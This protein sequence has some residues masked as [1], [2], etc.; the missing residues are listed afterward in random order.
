MCLHSS[1]CALSCS[2]CAH[3][4]RVHAHQALHHG[5]S[6]ITQQHTRQTHHTQVFPPHDI[7]PRVCQG[8]SED[9]RGVCLCLWLNHTSSCNT[10]T[11]AREQTMP[12]YMASKREHMMHMSTE[13]PSVV[14]QVQGRQHPI[15]VKGTKHHP[16]RHAH[17]RN[18]Q[19]DTRPQLR[20]IPNLQAGQRSCGLGLCIS[21]VQ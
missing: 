18:L 11:S 7:K 16:P 15:A 12:Q 20:T 1:Q 2:V 21:L 9:I 8:V 5:S 19:A 4:C 13:T 17:D 14:S 6:K 3:S 10:L